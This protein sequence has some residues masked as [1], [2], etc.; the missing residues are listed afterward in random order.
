MI[1]S[2][3]DFLQ[4]QNV[5]LVGPENVLFLSNSVPKKEINVVYL[6]KFIIPIKFLHYVDFVDGS[7][8]NDPVN[9]YHELLSGIHMS[10]WVLWTKLHQIFVAYSKSNKLTAVPLKQ[11]RVWASL[12]VV[13]V[14]TGWWIAGSFAWIIK[15][16]KW[17]LVL[18]PIIVTGNNDDVRRLN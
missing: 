4:K 3:I 7:V 15:P 13:K 2:N 14:P 1:S 11:S 16:L 8:R 5:V 17:L 9:G 6:G 12:P 18:F 10:C